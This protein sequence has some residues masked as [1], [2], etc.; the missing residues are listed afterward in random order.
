RL[1]ARRQRPA[2]SSSPAPATRAPSPST[3]VSASPSK[4]ASR[5]GWPC[6]TGPS[7]T[8]SRW[9][10]GSRVLLPGEG[11][12]RDKLAT[13]L[14]SAPHLLSGGGETMS[15]A[16]A[17]EE[18]YL[19]IDAV[20]GFAVCGILLMNIV[21]MGMPAFAYLNP[22]YWGG[23]TGAD[24]WTWAVNNV[25][26]DGKMRGLFT[27]LFGASTVLIADRAAA[28]SEGP[29]RT[30]YSR[31]FW[32][33]WFG[34]VHAYFLWWGDILVCYA[35]AGLFISPFRKLRPAILIGVGA[36]VLAGL[37]A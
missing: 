22:V 3:S 25:L 19:S 16:G 14:Q 1:R 29:I 7:K 4:A 30:H 27:I 8:T 5:A 32:L 21:G 10:S 6:P 28:N 15:A 24:L 12:M 23:H 36:V 17:A 2:S 35:V 37:I 20:R 33:F 26:T 18:R 31:M 11:S 34:M 9:P 13:T